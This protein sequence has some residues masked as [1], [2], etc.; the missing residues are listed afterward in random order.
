MK[1]QDLI[2]SVLQYVVNNE[3]GEGD[4]KKRSI[5]TRDIAKYLNHSEKEIQCLISFLFF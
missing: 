3:S 2:I 1:E 5:S 4:R